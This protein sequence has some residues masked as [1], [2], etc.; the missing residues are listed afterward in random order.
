MC[1]GGDDAR[2]RHRHGT[3]S[4][5]GILLYKYITEAVALLSQ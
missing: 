4:G 2:R 3:V 5:N 1:G